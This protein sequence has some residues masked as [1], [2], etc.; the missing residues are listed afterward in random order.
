MRQEFGWWIARVRGLV[1]LAVGLPLMLLSAGCATLDKDSSPE[2]KQAAVTE[3]AKARWT[4]EIKGDLDAAYTY[5]SPA[6]KEVVSLA[7]Y[8]GRGRTVRITA[9]DIES[10]KCEALSCK[11][12]VL[13]TFDHRLMKGIPTPLEE[14]WVIE[15]GQAWYVS[16]F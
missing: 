7:A 9:A 15:A 3:R 10:V 12:R 14:D 13:L 6:T 16:R 5:L 4:A 11:V 8:K 2:A 1:V